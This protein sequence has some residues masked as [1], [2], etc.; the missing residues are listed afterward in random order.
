M[1]GKPWHL[2]ARLYDLL[3]I[4][5]ICLSVLAII[6]GRAPY[7]HDFAEWLYQGQIVKNAVID[8]V[9][10]SQFTLAMY[11]VPNSL[12]T[13]LLAGLSLLF[14]PLWAGKVFLILMIL[15]WAGVIRLFARRFVDVQWRGATTLVLFTST[16]L[17]TFFW[18]GFTSY[19]LA[20]L[21]LTWFFARYREDTNAFVI[22][23]FAMGIFFAHAMIF[24]VFGLFLGVRLLLK[25]NHG[26]VLGLLPATA[27]SL[28]FL[29]GRYIAKVEPQT[30][31]ANW[32]GL[33]E[34]LIYK[35]GY[36]AMLGPFKNFLLPD[37]S[38]LLENQAWI[39]W[40]GFIVNFV[41]V[42]VL[43][44]LVLAVLWNYLKKETS[45]HAETSLLR[46]AWAI[47]ML[48]LI[49]FYLF[50]PYH[51][52]GLVNA[53]GRVLI[54]LVLM[55]FMLGEGRTRPFVRA[56]VW[57]VAVF[58]LITT[59]SYFYLMLQTR[60]SDFSPHM[61][62]AVKIS[63]SDSVLDFNEQLYAAT[64][65]KYFNYRVFAFARRFDQIESGHYHGL[66]FRHAMLIKFEPEDNMEKP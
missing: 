48:L 57:P 52:F 12:V 61:T 31:D 16:A 45:D 46:S 44:I 28:W 29:M 8:P 23:A 38:S 66:T 53:G 37:G 54:P 20:L 9:S 15:G 62:S 60:A 26:V 25:W 55:A 32:S 7:L 30:I 21:L 47:S 41:V 43:G 56:V 33:R 11:P 64:R 5:I 40:P 3:L 63:A 14:P 65:Y 27:C 18:Y 59:G 42:A 58:A 10:V 4:I 22:A 19:Q 34:A 39:Y 2:Q 49:V 51:F 6:F 35:A 24:L 36:P 13:V 1:T 50:A 17:A